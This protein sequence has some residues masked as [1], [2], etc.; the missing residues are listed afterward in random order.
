MNEKF[1]HY[2]VLSIIV[3]F[4]ILKISFMI[5][6]DYP[7]YS[8]YYGL[9]Y[10]NYVQDNYVPMIFDN[11][12]YQ[13]RLIVN[14]IPFY[15]IL[16]ILTLI[17]PTLFFFKF[18]NMFLG[19]LLIYLI[20]KLLIKFNF[21]PVIALLITIIS[22]LVPL[23]FSSFLNSFSL[24]SFFAI[25]CLLLIYYFPNV[26]QN[27]DLIKFIILFVLATIISPY[28][29]IL[30]FGFI[31]YFILLKLLSLPIKKNISELI[32]F[33]SLFSFWYHLIFYK[34]SLMKYGF[35]IIW[36]NIPE[37]LINL[38]YIKI[39]PLVIIIGLG[40]IPLILGLLGL[41]STLFIKPKKNMLIVASFTIIFTIISILGIIPFYN[42]LIILTIFSLILSANG[43]EYL[44]TYL[45]N[46][47]LQR[48][49]L[50]LI[51]FILVFSI[52]NFM[53]VLYDS[54]F[55]INSPNQD[56]INTMNFLKENTPLESTILGDVVEG[57][58]INFQANRKNFYDENFFLMQSANQ[59]YQDARIVFLSKSRAN[60][61]EQLNY[62]NIDYIYFSKLTKL[63]YPNVNFLIQND[64]CF[65]KIFFTNTTE[66]Y[67][68]KC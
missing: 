62:Y 16:S 27:K 37:G 63:R 30:V 59:R 48:F 50:P 68:R 5:N 46:T 67:K 33:F 61:L 2:I 57:H 38:S 14:N 51:I 9:R 64:E 44:F 22:C 40:F 39:T 36:Q 47:L 4:L 29:L 56:E 8:S 35:S 21:N 53:P 15:M 19:A 49:K 20:Y 32:L 58:L 1:S 7:S 65:E 24:F 3:L 54:S 23:I 11:L 55:T 60:I 12:S 66:V 10:V 13:G 28:S 43:L 18:I 42:A 45:D 17:I 31:F 26:E 6:V 41:Y 25:I 52:F 34:N